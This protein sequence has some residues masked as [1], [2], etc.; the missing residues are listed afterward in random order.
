MMNFDIC[1]FKINMGYFNGLLGIVIITI[2]RLEL[3]L[4]NKK[5]ENYVW[6]VRISDC[7]RLIVCLI[8]W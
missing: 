3:M 2:R 7:F 1:I 6:F 5:M 4:A 8:N